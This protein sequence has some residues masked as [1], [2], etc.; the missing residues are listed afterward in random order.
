MM[1]FP[2]TWSCELQLGFC[3]RAQKHSLWLSAHNLLADGGV[4]LGRVDSLPP[5]C[6]RNGV[7]L[8]LSS[9]HV[10]LHTFTYKNKG[11]GKWGMAMYC[12]LC[13]IVQVDKK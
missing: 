3:T 9:N 13:L 7:L 6:C 12:S 10:H 4:L 8:K 1:A 11:L 2:Y 5:P